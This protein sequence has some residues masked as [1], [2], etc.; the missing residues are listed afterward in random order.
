MKKITINSDK[1][2]KIYITLLALTAELYFY[3]FFK[4]LGATM[5]SNI[6]S[7]WQ[8]I[9]FGFV[10]VALIKIISE[11]Q[12]SIW[13]DDIKIRIGNIFPKSI[14]YSDIK[15][16]EIKENITI[17]SKDNKKTIKIEIIDFKNNQSKYKEVFEIISEQSRLD[18]NID[19]II[20]EINKVS[21]IYKEKPKGMLGYLNVYLVISLINLIYKLSNYLNEEP[22][23]L[24]IIFY[25]SIILFTICLLYLMI[26]KFKY[27]EK[28]LFVYIPLR[29]FVLNVL[30]Q[31]PNWLLSIT[32]NI[33]F[34][35]VSNVAW[36]LL[37]LINVI[38]IILFYRYF[39]MSE[40]AKHTFTNNSILLGINS[41]SKKN[42][43]HPLQRKIIKAGIIIMIAATI[44]G[45]YLIVISE[46]KT[47]KNYYNSMTEIID[48]KY[49]NTDAIVIGEEDYFFII[50]D[51]EKSFVLKDSDGKYIF[52]NNWHE[53]TKNIQR[54]GGIIE[55]ESIE[56]FGSI[57]VYK[58]KD[59][60]IVLITQYVV[61]EKNSDIIVYDIYSKWEWLE[62]HGSKYFYKI[63]DSEF[64]DDNYEINAD[65]Y[66][67]SYNL[68]NLSEL[69][70]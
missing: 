7:V 57:T 16:I 30:I 20:S 41:S 4:K 61:Q 67:E 58:H 36:M 32:Q 51:E 55:I 49:K 46:I 10:I 23:A 70:E 14:F 25:F 31:K 43:L 47:D 60:Y 13:L 37:L 65:I 38:I 12:C 48:N 26:N 28:L 21:E 15:K 53:E 40:L 11:T 66:N 59:N 35:L 6:I 42:K 5:P 34:D 69:L 17:H 50:T 27:F 68:A 2:I 64:V 62:R 24:N 9:I 19:R 63:I 8:I 1:K 3:F 29:F 33:N 44:F 52:C 56:F 22:T 45:A 54:G 39:R 18:L